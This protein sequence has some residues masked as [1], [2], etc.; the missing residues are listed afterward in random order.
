MS[1][2]YYEEHEKYHP[3]IHHTQVYKNTA[4]HLSSPCTMGLIDTMEGTLGRAIQPIQYPPSWEL[5]VNAGCTLLEYDDAHESCI[6]LADEEE[7][8]V[9]TSAPGPQQP[10]MVVYETW[11]IQELQLVPQESVQFSTV[12]KPIR[13]M[14]LRDTMDK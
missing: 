14:K 8:E 6:L 4:P 3:S 2:S 10:I 13:T 7:S 5:N 1:T 12:S 11:R 9:N